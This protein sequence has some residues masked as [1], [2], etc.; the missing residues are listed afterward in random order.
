M[1]IDVTSLASGLFIFM[2]VVGIASYFIGKKKTQSPVKAGA[3]GFVFSFIPVLGFIYLVY[4]L[5][6]DDVVKQ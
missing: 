5:M 3:M 1:N 2:L 4:L 6:K